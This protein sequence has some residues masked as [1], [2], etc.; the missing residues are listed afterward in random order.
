MV[1]GIKKDANYIIKYFQDKVEEL[2]KSHMYT[3]CFCF[4]EQQT[5]K[6]WGNSLILLPSSSG[7]INPL[8]E[9]VIKRKFI[10]WA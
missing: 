1:K 7:Y 8:K 5:Y 9:S 10:E 3:D 2:D 6:I 4:M